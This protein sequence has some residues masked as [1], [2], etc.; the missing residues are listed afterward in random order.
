[1]HGDGE[2][3]V[4][5][6]GGWATTE[7]EEKEE[8]EE[9][10]EDGGAKDEV[11][12]AMIRHDLESDSSDPGEDEMSKN[13]DVTDFLQVRVDANKT[14]MTLEDS[15]QQ[16]VEALAELLRDRP[17]LPPV[18]GDGSRSW[19]EVDKGICLPVCHCAFKG[20]LWTSNCMPCHHRNAHVKVWGV[21]DGQWYEHAARKE[22]TQDMFSCCGSGASCLR[23]HI[24]RDH[25]HALIACCGEDAIRQHSYDYYLEAILVREEGHIPVLGFSV[26][27]RVCLQVSI[28]NTDTATRALVCMCCAQI[29]RT[30]NALNADMGLVKAGLYLSLLRETSFN[31]NYCYIRF[32]KQFGSSDVLKDH[33]AL[34]DNNWSWKRVVQKE[35]KKFCAS[36][37]TSYVTRRTTPTFCVTS[38]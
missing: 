7:Q 3:A 37:K 29:Q 11:P 5:V 19:T 10:E 36:R 22:L 24:M 18:P 16:R 33:P 26:D 27:R 34:S 23:E 38:A 8:E 25:L 35:T 21:H 28:N 20:C 12:N 31:F 6:T 32:W 9:E 1:M 17:L 4:V 2:E 13:E 15:M 14:W 30:C